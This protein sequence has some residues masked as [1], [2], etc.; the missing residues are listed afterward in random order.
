M[1]DKLYYNN[2]RIDDCLKEIVRRINKTSPFKTLAS[3]CG[4]DVYNTTIVMK[5]KNGK[6]FELF[7]KRKLEV[8]KR[9]RYYKKDIKGYY[10]IPEIYIRK[11]ENKM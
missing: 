4:H 9:N 11:N 2:P 6:V 1:C 7:S 10:Y 3:C 5:D 8:K